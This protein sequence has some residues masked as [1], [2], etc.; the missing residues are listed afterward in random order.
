MLRWALIALIVAVVL[1]LL[2]FGAASGLA[3]KA[4]VILFVVF[5]ILLVLNYAGRGPTDPTGV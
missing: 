1:A 3:M 4:A 2:G 5:L